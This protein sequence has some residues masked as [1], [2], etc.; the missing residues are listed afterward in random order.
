MGVDLTG[1]NSSLAECIDAATFVT[2]V[3]IPDDSIVPINQSFIK[4]WRIRNSGT[5]IWSESYAI[6]FVGGHRL[7]APSAVAFSE[8][9]MPGSS[10]DIGISLVAP[11]ISGSYQGNWQLRNDRGEAFGVD[12]NHLFWVKINVTD[13]TE[14]PKNAES[15]T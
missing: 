15:G 2:D 1:N 4:T 13:E 5:C 12:G 8:P 11:D 7:S 14:S 10:V 6:T 3:T 9:V